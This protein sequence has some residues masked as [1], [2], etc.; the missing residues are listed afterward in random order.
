MLMFDD[1]LAADGFG[2]VL[3]A[4][5]PK[6]KRVRFDIGP[7]ILVDVLDGQNPVHHDQNVELCEHARPRVE[8]A[9]R[10]AFTERPANN[11]ELV[12]SDFSER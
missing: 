3:W 5:E 1:H 4:G 2:C 12:P 7:K 9:C 6:A 11:I 8:A 10:R